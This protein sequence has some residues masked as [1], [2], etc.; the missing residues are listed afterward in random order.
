[1]V[2]PYKGSSTGTCTT[3]KITY[4]K[5]PKA[6]AGVVKNG[7]KVKWSNVSGAKN[8]RVYR[9]TSSGKWAT[10]K[11]VTARTSSLTD[12]KAKKG[13]T[14]L[15]SVRALNGKTYSAMSPSVKVKRK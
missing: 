9:R 5:T 7:I 11:T 15:Y 1:M 13:V 14:Y 4:I 2:K 10:L 6:S 3:S 8:Y 12:T